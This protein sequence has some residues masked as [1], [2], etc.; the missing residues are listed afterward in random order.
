[1]NLTLYKT[2]ILHGHKYNIFKNNNKYLFDL[3]VFSTIHKY[4]TNKYLINYYGK[5]KK[6]IKIY[7]K[8]Y[9]DWEGMVILCIKAR[10]DVIS[11]YNI[12]IDAINENFNK[13]DIPCSDEQRYIKQIKEYFGSRYEYIEQFPNIKSS[14]CSFVISEL[15]NR[16]RI[17]LVIM[18]QNKPLIF[19]EIDEH[20]H[21][22]Q[23]TQDKLRERQLLISYNCNIV[24]LK[25]YDKSFNFKNSLNEIDA[26][27]NN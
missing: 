26:L 10:H 14:N 5:I 21:K 1:M 4:S 25:L 13:F 12:L 20:H 15:S 16:Y 8:I 6:Y 17:D 19:I 11:S 3:L 9:T 2:V 23:T 27:L 22:Y 7:D 18:R 24:R